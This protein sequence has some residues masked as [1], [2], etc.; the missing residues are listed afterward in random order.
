MQDVLSYKKGPMLCYDPIQSSMLITKEDVA[1]SRGEES[2]Q[3]K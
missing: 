2:G 1:E 3:T